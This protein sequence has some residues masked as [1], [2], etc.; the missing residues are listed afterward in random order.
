MPYAEYKYR[1][2]ERRVGHDDLFTA[3]RVSEDNIT[4]LRIF[5]TRFF[6][7]SCGFGL[8]GFRMSCYPKP[9]PNGAWI[10]HGPARPPLIIETDAIFFEAFTEL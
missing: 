8:E 4:S 10:V 5:C 2:R 7:S 3:V 9:I 6:D 1:H